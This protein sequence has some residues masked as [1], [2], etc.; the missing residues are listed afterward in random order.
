MIHKWDIVA[1]EIVVFEKINLVANKL[2][3]ILDSFF[4][5]IF[6]YIIPHRIQPLI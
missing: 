3:M 4:G 6:L 2:K 1:V 5:F